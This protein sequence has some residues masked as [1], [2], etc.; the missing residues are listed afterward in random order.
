MSRSTVPTSPA[1][2]SS[3]QREYGPFDLDPCATAENAKCAR[4]FSIADDGLSQEWRG[5]VFV[6]PPYERGVIGLWVAKARVEYEAGRAES[7]LLLIPAGTSTAWWHEHVEGHAS[8]IRFLKGRGKYFVHP[9]GSLF[10]PRF[11]PVLVMFG[12]VARATAW[13]SVDRR[14]PGRAVGLVNSRIT[15]RY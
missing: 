9:S 2:F 8:S 1:F 11:E 6:N 10:R 7:V 14:E 3:L 12:I 15:E 4:Y 13:A 5:R